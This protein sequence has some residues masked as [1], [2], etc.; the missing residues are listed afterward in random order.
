MIAVTCAEQWID[1]L[2]M[3]EEAGARETLDSRVSVSGLL[4]QVSSSSRLNQV[5]RV[6]DQ[7]TI[8][9][10]KMGGIRAVDDTV[11]VG[12]IQRHH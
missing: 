11:I 5:I 8:A 2:D 12:Q 7:V 1:N 6:T 10:D 3:D 9:N 4:N